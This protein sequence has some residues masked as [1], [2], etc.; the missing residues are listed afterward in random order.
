VEFENTGFNLIK[1]PYKVNG[2]EQRMKTRR[3]YYLA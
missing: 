2:G 3:S 1:I